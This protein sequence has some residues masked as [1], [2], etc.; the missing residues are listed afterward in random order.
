MPSNHLIP[1]IPEGNHSMEQNSFNTK[2]S[3]NRLFPLTIIIG[4]IAI[5]AIG[6]GVGYSIG[7]KHGPDKEK[8]PASAVSFAESPAESPAEPSDSEAESG[9]SAGNVEEMAEASSFSSEIAESVVS[10]PEEI[11][12]TPKTNGIVVCIDPG[13]Q[14]HGMSETEPN[15]PGSGEMKA[16]LTTGTQ[17]VATGTPEYAAVLEIGLKLRNIL[18]ERGYEVVMTRV[19]NQVNISN[20]DRAQIAADAGADVFIRLHCNGSENQSVAGALAYQPTGGN[21]YLTPELIEKSQRLAALVLEYQT[22]KTGQKSYGVIAGDDMTGINWAQ[23]PVTIIEMGYMSN[24]DEDRY[25]CS[26]EGQQTIAEGL[27]NG[28]DAFAEENLG[29]ECAVSDAESAFE[30]ASEAA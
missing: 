8:P 24:P 16:K 13:H 14:D 20:V 28:I 2:M 19:S 29:L 27:A 5:L 22:K 10:V 23:M 11:A 26:P 1:A 15:G 17:G 25:L 7:L 12:E 30:S 4:A 6:I 3:G 21:R 18:E 9:I